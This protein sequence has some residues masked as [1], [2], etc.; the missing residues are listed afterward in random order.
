MKFHARVF[1]YDKLA[2]MQVEILPNFRM[3]YSRLGL[4]SPIVF[5][6]AFPLNYEMW[7]TQ[8]DTLQ[9]KYSCVS[10]NARGFGGTSQFVGAPSIKQQA[11]DLNALLNALQISEPI[12]LCGLSMGGYTALSYVRQFPDRVRALILCDTRAEAD[13]DEAKEKRNANIEFVKT[14]GAAALVERVLPTLLGE[15]TQREN[16]EL[17]SQVKEWGGAQSASTLANALETLRDRPDATSWLSQIRVPTLLIFGEEDALI[18]K[19]AINT[20]HNGIE[21]SKLEIIPRAGHLSNLE[22]SNAFN[23]ALVEFLNGL[24]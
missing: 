9:D 23:A 20:L 2:L 18:P 3:E 15:T 16:P 6:H 14:N 5:L 22:N 12:I 24:N 11:H 17:V 8:I 21:N 1:C 10:S 13:S 7:R 4:G 19:E